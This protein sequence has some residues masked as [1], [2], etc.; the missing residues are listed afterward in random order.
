MEYKI[1]DKF[2]VVRE[3]R[4]EYIGKIITLREFRNGGNLTF[5]DPFNIDNTP[6]GEVC[7]RTLKYVYENDN[8]YLDVAPLSP[9]LKI[10]MGE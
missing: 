7:P 2:I 5:N 10:I 1:G 4:P 3:D 6:F 9:A 8:V